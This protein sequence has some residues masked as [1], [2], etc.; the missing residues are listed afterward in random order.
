MFK[1]K[2]LN[3]PVMSI[4]KNEKADETRLVTRADMFSLFGRIMDD[5]LLQ[6]DHQSVIINANHGAVRLLGEQLIGDSL[7]QRIIYSELMEDLEKCVTLNEIREFAATP[8]NNEYHHIQGKIMPFGNERVLVLLM[9]MTLQHNLEKIRRDFIA[10]VSHELRSPLTSLIGFVETLQNTPDI[11]KNM[12]ERFLKIMEEESRRMSR[13]ID[14]LMSLSRVEVAEHIAPTGKVFIK[15]LLASV[16]ASL[17][18]RAIKTGHVIDLDDK[19]VHMS[20]EPI[21]RGEVDEITE[22]FHNLIDNALKYSYPE[23]IITVEMTDTASGQII[24]DI[25][26]RG[27]GI[28][29]RHIPRLTER[30]YRVDKGRSRQMGGTGL[31]LAIVKHIVNKHRGQLIITSQLKEVTMFRVM[32]PYFHTLLSGLR[33]G[34]DTA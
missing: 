4:I 11:E 17:N 14:D 16:I 5:A 15:R 28:E 26:N 25:I 20:D 7:T 19:R 12:L 30:F 27:D 29:E 32:I 8:S 34:D 1:Y 9:D 23:S 24:I 21:V 2:P 33:G 18:N 3:V 31:G 6:I 10:N 22:V 13:L